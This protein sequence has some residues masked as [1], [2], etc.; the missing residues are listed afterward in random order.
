MIELSEKEKSLIKVLQEGIPL[1]RRPFKRLGEKLDL[2]ENQIISMI[3]KLKENKII[4]QISPIYDTK[5]LGYDSSLVAFKITGDVQK[6]AQIVNT[7]PG[8]S[9]NYERNDVFNMWFTIAVPP[10]SKLGLEQTVNLLAEMTDTEDFVILR[11]VKLYKI[12]VKLDFDNLKEKEQLTKKEPLKKVILSEEDK[13]IIKIT[14]ED[15]PL[16]EDPFG[17]YAERIG[18]EE[19]KLLDRLSYYQETGV[20][21]RFAAILYHRKAGFKANGMTVW[22]VPD[23]IVDEIGY[24]VAAYRSVTHC[25]KRTVNEKWKYNLFSMIHGRTKEELEDFVKEL[26][27]EIGIKD[28]KI[29]YSTQEFKKRRIKYFSEDFYTWEEDAENGRYTQSNIKGKEG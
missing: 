9:H 6:A 11:T 25:Y 27:Q 3:Q 15:I 5:S 19:G 20:M 4:R 29:L 10:D 22:N 1:E 16:V 14:Q 18:I 8:V 13:K 21:R 24:R 12:G 26:S 23:S 17:V 7:H 28:Y 2:T